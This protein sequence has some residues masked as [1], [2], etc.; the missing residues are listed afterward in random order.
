VEDL[1]LRR[2]HKKITRRNAD[3]KVE[4]LDPFEHSQELDELYQKY[5]ESIDFDGYPNI[6]LG[7]L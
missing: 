7:H 3:T 1:L 4:L 2:S 6:P 5:F